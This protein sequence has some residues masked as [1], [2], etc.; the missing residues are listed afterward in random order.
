[1]AWVVAT[2]MR[3]I[4]RLFNWHSFF[5]FILKVELDCTARSIDVVHFKS[6]GVSNSSHYLTKLREGRTI[7]V[8]HR[9]WF[10]VLVRMVKE[11]VTAV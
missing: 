6:G 3:K 4:L 9:N 5:L 8:G 10:T 2:G 7:K 11:I 1:M